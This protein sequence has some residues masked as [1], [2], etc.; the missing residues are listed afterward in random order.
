MDISYNNG[1]GSYFRVLLHVIV[2]V[3]IA[4][5]TA[6]LNRHFY[7]WE[8]A[9]L[10]SSLST[11][12]LVALFYFNAKILVNYFIP[13]KQY[14]FYLFVVVLCVLFL[15]LLRV[16]INNAFPAEFV[17]VV[18]IDR[19]W[20]LQLFT[21]WT[22]MAILLVSTFYQISSNLRREEQ[23]SL[24]FENQYKEAQLQFLKAQINPHFLFNTLNNI[25]TLAM[26]KS[27]QTGD[28]VLL[29]SDLL[30]YVIY[31]GQKKSVQLEDEVE[32][33]H[34]YIELF[35]IKNQ[36][37]ELNVRFDVKGD[38]SGIT[39]EPMILIPLVENCFKHCDYLFN[40]EAFM[41]FEL[42]ANMD[43]I[44]F[45]AVNTYS[46]DDSQKDKT[47]GVGLS[48][49]KDRLELNHPD[50]HQLQINHNE[51]TFEVILHITPTKYEKD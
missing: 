31:E 47:G 28:M 44:T 2:W 4:G 33:I 32:Y 48:N 49:I 24:K 3:V 12:M 18:P 15:A 1:K 38:F 22:S 46:I 41:H 8:V 9:I 13:K 51:E 21:F 37:R 16:F 50:Q 35:K 23:K 34:K 5:L 40:K 27:D 42:Y 39:I 17:Q 11:L 20:A 6:L 19:G 10:R 29:L 26:I 7:G 14:L 45:R 36:N 30:R 25:Y 43:Q